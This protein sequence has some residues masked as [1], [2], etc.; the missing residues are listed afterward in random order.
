M[1][2][3]IAAL[4]GS[5][6]ISGSSGCNGSI[7]SDDSALR[8]RGHSSGGCNLVTMIRKSRAAVNARQPIIWINDNQS[9]WP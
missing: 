6:S 7:S 3:L 8:G 5:D 2:V 1:V 4:S 9:F